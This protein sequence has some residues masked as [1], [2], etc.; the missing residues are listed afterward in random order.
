MICR[1]GLVGR[2]KATNRSQIIFINLGVFF[3]NFGNGFARFFGALND[4][5]IHIGDIARIDNMILAVNMAQD[6]KQH[7]RHHGG[8]G[9]A[10]MGIRIN[11]RPAIIH[12]HPFGVLR[13]ESLFTARQRI[14]ER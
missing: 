12:R 2:R 4:T 11:R 1:L 13:D 10:D 8:A 6:S 3:R 14:I 5:V 9:I 7:I